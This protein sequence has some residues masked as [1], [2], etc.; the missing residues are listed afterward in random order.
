[1]TTHK[2]LIGDAAWLVDELTLLKSMVREVPFDE[3][4]MGQDS[5]LDLLARIGEAANVFFLPL[6]QKMTKGNDQPLEWSF[7][8]FDSRM[9]KSRTQLD[10]P[11]V[12]LDSLISSRR[13]V[14]GLL[15]ELDSQEFQKTF[16]FL[17]GDYDLTALVESMV[18]YDRKQLKSVAER[19]LL[20]DIEK[21]HG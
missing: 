18:R 14:I 5:V 10:D 15:E 1:M 12:L 11:D 20:M 2:Q 9:E 4:P 19:M 6:I 17:D 3:R 16:V 13:E 8:D 7:R 21:L